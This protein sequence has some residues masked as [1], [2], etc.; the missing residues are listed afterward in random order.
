MQSMQRLK[1]KRSTAAGSNAP[2][3]YYA[4]IMSQ[5]PIDL[6]LNLD[7]GGRRAP[8]NAHCRHQPKVGQSFPDSCQQKHAMT[9]R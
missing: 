6:L 9:L 3:A 2:V 4:E 1:G 8:R 5:T 7:L